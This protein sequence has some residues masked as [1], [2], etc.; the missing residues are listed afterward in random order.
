MKKLMTLT[1][2]VG[3]ALGLSGVVQAQAPSGGPCPANLPLGTWTANANGFQGTLWIGAIDAA[4]NITVGTITLAGGG[5]DHIRG[6]WTASACKITFMR[7]DGASFNPANALTIQAFTGYVYPALTTNPY[8]L[9]K[10]AGY[11]EAFSPVS[12]GGA[13]R[14]VFGWDAYRY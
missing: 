1:M 4:G 3:I 12:G 13:A 6:F 11:L 9:K 14:H 8:G 7:V 5:V 2:A 10:M